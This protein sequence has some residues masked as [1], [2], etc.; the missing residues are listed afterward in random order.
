MFDFSSRKNDNVTNLEVLN[1][2]S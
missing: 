2:C 1:I